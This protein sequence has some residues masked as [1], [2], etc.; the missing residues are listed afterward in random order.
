MNS[1]R[2]PHANKASTSSDFIMTVCF[3]APVKP[4]IA[5]LFVVAFLFLFYTVQYDMF[6]VNF[7]RFASWIFRYH[8][9]N[10]SDLCTVQYNFKYC[11]NSRLQVSLLLYGYPVECYVKK[12]IMTLTLRRTNEY[13]RD[14]RKM[15]LGDC[16]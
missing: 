13:S 16:R 14:V 4:S 5:Y 1:P 9:S 7:G 2:A 15:F 10:D 8:P 3:A 12:G 6:A 11:M